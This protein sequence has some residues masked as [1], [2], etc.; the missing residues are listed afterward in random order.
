MQKYIEQIKSLDNPTFQQI[1]SIAHKSISHLSK[2]ADDNLYNQL[3]RGV[4]LLDSH[5]LMCKYLYSYGNMHE[6]K[7]HDALKG[8]SKVELD[9]EFDII[10]WGCGQGIA[11]IAFYDYI[12]KHELNLTINEIILIEPSKMALE[13]AE[14]HLDAFKTDSSKIR[15][16]K[17]YLNDVTNKDIETDGSRPV[18]HFF[19][20]ILDIKEIDLKDIAVKLSNSFLNNNYVISVGPLN[21]G[22]RRIDA[23]YDYFEVSKENLFCDKNESQFVY[24]YNK[25]C[26]YK[27]KVYKLE[28]NE[29]GILIPI[30][31]YPSVQFHAGYELDSLKVKRKQLGFNENEKLF[32]IIENLT[33]FETSTP[34]DIG[35]SVYDDVHPILAVLNNIVTRGLPTKASKFIEELFEKSFGYSAPVITRGEISYDLIKDRDIAYKNIL[36]WV[37]HTINSSGK[38]DYASVDPVQ[39]QLMLSP[40]AIARVQ[41]TILEALMT[42]QLDINQ[43]SWEILVEE[44]DIPCAAI[45]FKDLEQMFNNLTQLSAEYQAL[46]FPTVNLAIISS[47]E[48]CSSPL[49]LYNKVSIKALPLQ[50]KSLFDLVIDISILEQSNIKKDSFSRFNCK[51]DC[52]FNIRSAVQRRSERTIYTSNIIKYRDLVRKDYQGKYNEIK[53]TKELLIYFMQLIFRKER[54]LPGQLPILN[55]AIQNNG[56]I[57]LLPTG[58]GKSLTYQLA[59]MLQPGVTLIVDPLSSLMK[60][61]YDGLVKA[62]V[63]CCTCINS[64]VRNEYE[65]RERQMESS[66]LLFVFLSP[67][68]LGIYKFRE[69]LKTMHDLNVYF[70][71]GVVD[72][73]HCV[74]EWGHDFRFSY[75]HLGRNLYKYVKA[76]EGSISL[77]GLTA[78][79]SFDVLADVERELSGEGAFILDADTIVRYENTNRLELQYKIEKVNVEFEEDKFFD[80]LGKL[81]PGLPKAVSFADKRAFHNAKNRFLA[82]YINILPKYI[83]ELQ[84]QDAIHLIKTSF[85]ERQEPDENFDNNLSIEMP[86]DFYEKKEYY[87]QAGIVFCPHKANTGIAVKPNQETLKKNIQDVGTFFGGDDSDNS[88]ENLELFRDSKQAIMVATKAFGMGIDKPNVRFTVNMNYSSSLE[89]FVQEAGR[90]GRDR[91]MA[92]S[93]ILL[94]DYKLAR[95]NKKLPGV[96]FPLSIIRN[97]WFRPDD[98]ETIIKHYKLQVDPQ[99]IDYCTP[100]KDFAQLHCNTDHKIFSFCECEGNCDDFCNCELSKVPRELKGWHYETDLKEMLADINIKID[101]KHIQFQNADYETVMFFYNNS[102]KGATIEKKFMHSLLSIDPIEIFY[103]DGVEV[104]TKELQTLNGFLTSLLNAEEGTEI[105]SLVPYIN[106]DKANKIDGNDVD[107][108]KAIYRMSCIGLISDYTQDYK[109]SRYRIVSKRKKE[110]EYFDGL[111]KFLLRY[112]SIDR[113]EQEINKACNY[114]LNKISINELENEIHRC[115]AYLTEF[116]YE[117]I[118]IKR[119][120]AI[121]DMRNFCIQGIDEK[122]DWKH[123]NEELK[124]FIYY[125]FNS[126]YAKEDYVTD[127][128]IPYS[129]TIDTDR[130]KVSTIETLFKYLKVV[131][132]ELVGVGTPIDNVKHLQGAVRLI[133]RSLTDK[134]PTLSLL[135]SFCLLYLGTQGNENL[136]NELLNS[137]KEGMEE[138]ENR[139]EDSSEFW[140]LFENYNAAIKQFSDKK[141]LSQLKNDTMLTIHGNKL[142]N[143]TDKYLQ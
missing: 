109:N 40:I 52:Y 53:E 44:H 104:K 97:K 8:I 110:G 26:T 66:Q 19:S 91:K 28:Y 30:A 119:K 94:S 102:F 140:N 17:K 121:D 47:T 20:N 27:A 100:Q 143:I 133:R 128:D 15:V 42:S 131:D 9:G 64:S 107:I 73:V 33:R 54:F 123:R 120:R 3:N 7:I 142:K 139:I 29:E 10:D 79:A 1:R 55:R 77:F 101:K 70:S 41:K 43:A 69:R 31:F 105:V 16:V 96:E 48:F 4:N 130:G 76:K 88:M 61:Q 113:A 13:R 58:G 114:K 124:D 127:N 57:G 65:L 51:N 84:T 25:E 95:I 138:F 137:Y 56:V 2:Q 78:T 83:N 87:K 60:D 45:A 118:S 106:A 63:D 50:I 86:D 36:L 6:A 122:S 108:A 59:A 103:G 99:Y 14:L 21:Y 141:Q 5:E 18:I 116:V 112:Y 35:A 37:N 117:K 132:D 23:F 98:L 80:K 49:H 82:N 38:P 68:R 67:E 71:Y 85:E 39:L 72:E 93:T 136:E 111:R 12:K 125:Y 75:L 89:S 46:K 24:G 126:K 134:N 129:L 11:T 34:F 90:A 62:G 32:P 135:N 22:N 81:D 74:S 92:L 115:L